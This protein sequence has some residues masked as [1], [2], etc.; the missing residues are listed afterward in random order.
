MLNGG[1][2]YEDYYDQ[3]KKSIA[4]EKIYK[5]VDIRKKCNDKQKIII[6]DITTTDKS[7]LEKKTKTDEDI[8]KIRGILMQKNIKDELYFLDCTSGKLLKYFVR[9]ELKLYKKCLKDQEADKKKQKVKINKTVKQEI[10]ETCRTKNLKIVKKD[11]NG[12]FFL[13]TDH[14]KNLNT[15]ITGKLT[16]IIEEINKI[17]DEMLSSKEVEDIVFKG[18][19]KDKDEWLKKYKTQIDKNSKKKGQ[20]GGKNRC[21]NITISIFP[22]RDIFL[23]FLWFTFLLLNGLLLIIIFLNICI[24]LSCCLFAEPMCG[25]GDKKDTSSDRV[26]PKQGMIDNIQ[27]VIEIF[28]TF[29][30]DIDN[31]KKFQDDKQ[32]KNITSMCSYNDPKTCFEKRKDL[33]FIKKLLKGMDDV[34]DTA[35][36]NEEGQDI[37][38]PTESDA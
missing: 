30:G 10:V 16:K 18:N 14:I 21:Y 5:A 8:K 11:M 23:N 24:Y 19:K 33:D 2:G 9:I 27:K 22:W 25:G 31:V 17:P 6:K 35:D 36:K 1:L 15:T 26:I 34:F 20:K 29:I 7:L 32:N 12:V 28:A 38:K 4:D 13:D 37:K 3:V